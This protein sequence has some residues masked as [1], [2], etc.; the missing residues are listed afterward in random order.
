MSLSQKSCVPC[1]GGVPPLTRK[2]FEP[3]MAELKDWQVI[4]DRRLKKSYKLQ[5]FAQALDLANKIG[6]IAE[7][8]GHHPDLLVRW[9]E[10]AIDLWT[11]KIDGLTE[12]DFILA[13]KIDQL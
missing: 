11:H 4:D 1:R 10:L 2:E 6:A 9:G 12:S 7:E 13:A 5:N 8:Q 3:L